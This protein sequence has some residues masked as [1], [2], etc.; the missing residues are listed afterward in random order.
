MQHKFAEWE[1]RNLGSRTVEVTIEKSDKCNCMIE[2]I[3]KIREKYD[4]QYVVVKIDP[5]LSEAN[6]MLQNNGYIMIE[7]QISLRLQRDEAVKKQSFFC[8]IFN[9]VTHR[10]ATSIE[11]IEFVKDEIKKG[12][13]TTDR[14]AVDKKFGIEKANNRY[15]YWL[16]DEIDKNS[17]LY[18]VND[19]CNDVA[20]FL[21]KPIN[22][23]LQYGLLGGV[24]LRE[25]HKN[26]YGALMDYCVLEEFVNSGKK[27]M[28]T[29]VSSNNI[30]VLQLHLAFGYKIKNITNVLVKHY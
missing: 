5:T 10:M 7:S 16:Q 9:G 13:F 21:N 8:N 2:D 23:N 22:D 3:E 12:I 18:I 29:G 27:N 17:V 24:F 28:E 20:F 30:A 15:A 26:G 14:I 1:I 6:Q 19:T 25:E 11:D 4:G